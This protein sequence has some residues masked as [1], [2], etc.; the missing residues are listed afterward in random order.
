[1]KR[2]KI[3]FWQFAFTYIGAIVGAGFASGQEILQFFGVFGLYGVVGA[4]LAGLLLAF[5][6]YTILQTVSFL[7]L[8]SYDQY[9]VYLFGPRRAKYFD[10]VIAL[11]LLCGLAVMLVAGGSLF[12]H[13]WGWRLETG[14]LLNGVFLYL[15]MLIG[16]KGMLWLNTLLIPGLIFISASIAVNSIG[17][18]GAPQSL[19]LESGF[20]MQNWLMAALLYVSYN[21]VLGMVVLVTLGETA[22]QVGSKGVFLGG[23]ILGLLAVLLS[24][25]LSSNL[26][27]INGRDLP[28]LIL[29]QR[30]QKQLSQL[31][32]FV[33]WAAIITTALGNGL[34]LVKRLQQFP[35]GPKPLVTALPFLPSLAFLGWPLMRAVGVIYPFLGYVGLVVILAIVFKRF[36]GRKACR[37]F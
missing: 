3:L 8:E 35:F 34:G 26:D 9:L 1:M 30:Q 10:G 33:L 7:G 13:L 29:A 4:S 18:G 22:R 32:A 36:C 12:S 15:V 20:L 16:I 14:F 21:V 19:P 25:A 6:G 17:S 31:F 23:L 27:L 11:F 28:L 2:G 5:F 24:L 37:H